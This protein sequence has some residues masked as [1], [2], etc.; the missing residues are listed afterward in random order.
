MA[1]KRPTARTDRRMTARTLRLV[2]AGFIDIDCAPIYGC[3]KPLTERDI[4]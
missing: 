2:I 4:T 1:D 3:A